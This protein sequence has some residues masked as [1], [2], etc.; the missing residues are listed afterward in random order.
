[1]YASMD[2]SKEKVHYGVVSWQTWL[3]RKHQYRLEGKLHIVDFN[4]LAQKSTSTVE[5][6]CGR[7][8]KPGVIG[9]ATARSDSTAM[10]ALVIMLPQ[11]CQTCRRAL[12]SGS[13]GFMVVS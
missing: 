8:F 3:P 1:M 13:A 10:L 12:E 9:A 4:P 7:E 11:M 5:T 6:L 2:F